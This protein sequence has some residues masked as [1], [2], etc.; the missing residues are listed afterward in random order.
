M[1]TNTAFGSTLI[2]II[3]LVVY[4]FVSGG[5]TVDMKKPSERIYSL[6]VIYDMI[7]EGRR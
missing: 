4:G 5:I 1:N 3:S 7:E 6:N 2:I